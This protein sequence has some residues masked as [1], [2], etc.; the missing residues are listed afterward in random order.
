M[1]KALMVF[2]WAC[3][4]LLG[5]AS[6]IWAGKLS[7][8]YN[9]WTTRSRERRSGFNPPPTPESRKRNTIIMTWILRVSGTF[10]ALLSILALRDVINTKLP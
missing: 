7:Q 3:P 8:R 1:L 6:V 4:A 10:L 9:A 5:I 2:Q